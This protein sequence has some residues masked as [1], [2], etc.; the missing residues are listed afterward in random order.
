MDDCLFCK[1]VEGTEP[2]EKV[3]ETE[4]FLVVKNKF[5]AA[6]VHVL[7]LDKKQKL[8]FLL[9]VKAWFQILDGKKKFLMMI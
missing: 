3:L 7:V 8:V 1:I 2:S 6:P 4:R 5:P 9:R